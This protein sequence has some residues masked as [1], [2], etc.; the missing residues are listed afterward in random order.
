MTLLLWVNCQYL[1]VMRGN[2]LIG[3]FVAAPAMFHGVGNQGAD[4]GIA[5]QPRGAYFYA[6]HVSPRSRRW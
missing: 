2:G 5:V 3:G 4:L 6:R 1:N